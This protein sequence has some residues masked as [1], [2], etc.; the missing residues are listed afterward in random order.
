VSATASLVKVLASAHGLEAIQPNGYSYVDVYRG[1][2]VVARLG[3]EFQCRYMASMARTGRFHG[4]LKT[5]AEVLD[6]VYEM[7]SK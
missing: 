4:G 2:E 3:H 1:S 6:W 7:E 5:P